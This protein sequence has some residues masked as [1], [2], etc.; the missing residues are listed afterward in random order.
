MKIGDKVRYRDLS[1]G[2]L[3]DHQG[4]IVK[5][6]VGPCLVLVRWKGRPYDAPEFEP[7]LEVLP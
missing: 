4:V 2:V 3:G 1:L 7:N 6:A 5:L